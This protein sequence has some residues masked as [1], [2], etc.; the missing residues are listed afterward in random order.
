ME[1]KI[2]EAIDLLRKNDYVVVKMTDRMNEDADKCAETGYGECTSCSCFIC[3]AG[4][5]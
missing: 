1:D 3:A 2:K 5:E 4:L